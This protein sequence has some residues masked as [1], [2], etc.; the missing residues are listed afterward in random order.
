MPGDADR[1]RLKPPP[2]RKLAWE[3]LSARELA[4]LLAAAPSLRGAPRGT[5]PV[6]VLPGFRLGDMSTFPMRQFLRRL[7][8]TVDGWGLGVNRGDVP[9]LMPQVAQGV[10]EIARRRGE[11]LHLIGQSL[12]GVLARETARD[13]PDLVA[14]V[15]TIG[16]P[17]VGGPSYTRVAIAYADQRLAEIRRRIEERDRTPIRVPITA[18]YS[19]HDGIVAWQ[20]CIDHA[21]PRV[22]HVEVGSS[23]LGMALDPTV[24]GLVAERLSEEAGPS[25]ASP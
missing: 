19:R 11:P 21:N 8:H 10:A 9:T 7:G 1:E 15:I 12:G 24:W 3:A 4:R 2:I 20:A 5:A 25:R 23:H 18:V 22:E 13:R 6:V 17:V 14:Q 16:S